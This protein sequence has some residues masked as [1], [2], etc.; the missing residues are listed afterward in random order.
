[1]ALPK[2]LAFDL[3]GCV[4][5]PEMYE[6]WGSGGSPFALRSD[7]DLTD[8]GGTAVRLM[9][10]ATGVRAVMNELATDAK[11]RGARVAAA[12][13]CD[14]PSWARECIGKFVLAEGR[15]LD[16]VLDAQHNQIYKGDKRGH[17]AKIMEGVE[18]GCTPAEA[19]F[20]DN[21]RGNCEDVARS[22]VTCVYC[23]EGVTGEVWASA[24][25][26]FPAPGEILTAPWG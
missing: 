4:W 10:G 15:A 19:I 16:D 3:D 7:G 26:R 8:S 9:G 24:I 21:Q 23:P 14:E 22:G 12:S 18:G 6:L 17:L 20:F 1:M 11:W 2:V 25:S 13:C 5:D